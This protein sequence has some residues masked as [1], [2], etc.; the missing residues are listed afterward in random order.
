MKKNYKNTCILNTVYSLFIYLLI[1]NEKE[2]SDTIFFMGQGISENI[3]KKLP[4]V[5]T[6]DDK[7]LNKNSIYRF[8]WKILFLLK[9][10]ICWKFIDQSKIYGHDHLVFS[11]MLVRNNELTVIEDGTANYNDST[12]YKPNVGHIR[13]KII[14]LYGRLVT[15]PKYGRSKYVDHVIVTG[16]MPILPI[17]KN[18]AIKINLEQLW[19]GCSDNKKKLILD[20]FNVR[21]SELDNYKGKKILLLTQP[22]NNVI[23]DEDL[24]QIYKT[25]LVKY[26]SKEVLIKTHP[27]DSI[28]YKKI[29][30]EYSVLDA[31]IPLELLSILGL[32]FEKAITISSTAVFCLPETTKKIFLGHE[33]HPDILRVYGSSDYIINRKK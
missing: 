33:C 16:I 14:R 15:E 2:I 26:S 5:I 24:I 32:N 8:M 3:A 19:K 23:S 13:K 10:N 11:P 17:I 21:K 12:D 28:V 27:R 20:I 7:F 6:I 29:F 25:E 1:K 22:F 9:R 18:K 30:N 4:N 31:P